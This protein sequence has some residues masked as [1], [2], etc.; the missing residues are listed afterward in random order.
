MKL[1]VSA[2][3]LNLLIY[4]VTQMARRQAF[5]S[6]HISQDMEA[7]GGGGHTQN[8]SHRGGIGQGEWDPLTEDAFVRI[9][10]TLASVLDFTSGH[11]NLMEKAARMDIMDIKSDGSIQI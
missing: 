6:F 9:A 11:F 8:E 1:Q 5:E 4:T 7:Y 2:Q 10:Y 3:L